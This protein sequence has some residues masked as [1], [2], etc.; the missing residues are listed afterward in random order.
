MYPDSESTAESIPKRKVASIGSGSIV[1][2]TNKDEGSVD[3]QDIEMKQLE[4]DSEDINIVTSLPIM[5]PSW[6]P[7][8]P[9]E[10][11]D[12][13]TRESLEPI[14]LETGRRDVQQV[15]VQLEPQAERPSF[16]PIEATQEE[17]NKPLHSTADETY[18][19][20]GLRNASFSNIDSK[21]K[22]YK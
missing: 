5:N 8:I 17:F 15:G 18:N 20:T 9:I 16:E 13:L 14:Y 12:N 21:Y 6:M 22:Q 7:T 3:H 11:L 19:L 2:S 1:K 10:L 4:A